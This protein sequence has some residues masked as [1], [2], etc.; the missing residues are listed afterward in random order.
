MS[1]K[2][3]RRRFVSHTAAAGTALG[4][5]GGA[6]W[7]PRLAAADTSLPAGAVQ[8]NP[9]VEPLVR[10]LETTTRERILPVVVEQI[11]GGT[12]YRDLLAAVFLAA[13]RN[14]Q[15]R[16]SVGFKFHSVLVV[17]SAH[18]ATLAA[19]DQDRWLPLLWAVDYFK[20]AQADDVSQGDWTMS[21][22][23]NVERLTAEAALAE[24]DAAMDAWDVEAADR[25]ATAAART[26]T[27][28]Q[29]LERFARYG[30]RD[31]RDIGHKA[32]YVAG[33]FRLLDTIGYEHTE[34]IVRSLAY[35]LLN[36][37]GDPN[38]AGADLAADRPGRDNW[39]RAEQAWRGTARDDA[40]TLEILD[41]FRSW[42]AQEAATEVARR[43]QADLHPQA[44][45][46]ALWLG[47]SELV[48]RQSA[49]VPLHAVTSSNALAF[50][51]R[52]VASPELRRWL[53]LQNTAFICLFREAAKGRG[54][55]RDAQLDALEPAG[56]ED[57]ADGA[58]VRDLEQLFSEVGRDRQRAA[59]HT[60]AYFQSGQPLDPFMRQARE[61][62]FR[63]GTDSHD[64]KF[65]SAV[66]E[67]V[68]GISPQW[69]SLY[70]A[71]CSHLLRGASEADSR[72][73]QQARSLL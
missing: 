72:L 33:A 56:G 60:L 37:Q 17:H 70:M 12:P 18:Q 11:R 27:S 13:I 66:L 59:S 47:A 61:L 53:L 15:P 43:L 1:D 64:Y 69:R 24:L 44:V 28:A 54:A 20:R 45:Y 40:A 35:A 58:G 21:E 46:D 30:S 62:V 29:L 25:A 51:H 42:S 38:P 39:Q 67:D 3:N 52:S 2:L 4:A 65:S 34:P 5:L 9:T 41:G 55:L 36:H 31:F 19:A 14:V 50:L 7:L 71:G 23:P 16:P 22:P 32:I 68:M 57:T 8:F 48:M 73:C 49:I 63:K 6:S 26:A 10:L